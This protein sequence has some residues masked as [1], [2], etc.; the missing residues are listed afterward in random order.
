MKRLNFS[1]ILRNL[2]MIPIRRENIFLYNIIV[3]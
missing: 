2:I 1:K 3:I